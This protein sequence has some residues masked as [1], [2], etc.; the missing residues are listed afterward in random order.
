M[1]K[2]IMIKCK[3]AIIDSIINRA[4]RNKEYM[5]LITDDSQIGQTDSLFSAIQCFMLIYCRRILF[6]ECN[7]LCSFNFTEEEK[8]IMILINIPEI[9]ENQLNAVSI[10]K[11]ITRKLKKDIR[12]T[13][14]SIQV[15]FL[16]FNAI[17][18]IKES[19]CFEMYI[20][21]L[22]LFNIISEYVMFI[23]CIIENNAP[24]YEIFYFGINHMEKCTFFISNM[25]LIFF[26]KFG[27]NQDLILIS[28]QYIHRTDDML[29]NEKKSIIRWLITIIEKYQDNIGRIEICHMNNIIEK[30]VKKPCVFGRLGYSMKR[31]L[32]VLFE[33]MISFVPLNELNFSYTEL[34]INFISKK[35]NS[36]LNPY[37]L[38][39]MCKTISLILIADESKFE[40]FDVIQQ[41]ESIMKQNILPYST[42]SI[43]LNLL[44]V[45][46]QT[47]VSFLPSGENG[48]YYSIFISNTSFFIRSIDLFDDMDIYTKKIM[49]RLWTYIFIPI[50]IIIKKELLFKVSSFIVENVN[51]EDILSFL[52]ILCKVKNYCCSLN[53]I[54][55]LNNDFIDLLIDID[56]MTEIVEQVDE[57][58]VINIFDLINFLVTAL[59]EG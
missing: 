42:H 13:E 50:D 38:Y 27:Y 37:I 45:L 16:L 9:P 56:I 52:I 25:I 33:S 7:D 18:M 17:L 12:K 24:I 55:F 59:S 1:V 23:P 11:Y 6:T 43:I 51:Y 57:N 31:E 21:L 28:L 47:E 22:K 54:E 15:I 26:D 53:L 19:D 20:N 32:L 30:L 39:L 29:I 36:N 8:E 2:L 41:I 49:L 10:I 58:L 5:R 35:F 14:I 3:E 34:I 44:I 48:N 4:F 46:I 40:C